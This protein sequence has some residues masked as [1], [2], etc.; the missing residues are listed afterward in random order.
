MGALMI[1]VRHLEFQYSKCL[2]DL[3]EVNKTEPASRSK[4]SNLGN[5]KVEVS[6]PLMSDLQNR[7]ILFRSDVTEKQ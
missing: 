5:E 3:D 7:R 1:T 2:D 6:Q 4:S